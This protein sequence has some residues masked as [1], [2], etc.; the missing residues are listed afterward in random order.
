ME[1]VDTLDYTNFLRFHTGSSQS[2]DLTI[3]SDHE[4]GI[5]TNNPQAKLQI[6]GG[7]GEQLRIHAAS[8]PIIQFTEGFLGVQEKKGF[9]QLSG[10]DL[11]I[12]TNSGNENGK[13]VVRTNGAD[14]ISVD[15][16][17]FVSVKGPL[18]AKDIRSETGVVS[19][20]P[21]SGIPVVDV[22]AAK[23]Q[24]KDNIPLQRI[25]HQFQLP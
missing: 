20:N 19:L 14:R 22:H 24:I 12:G 25:P 8:D 17:G 4:V 9:V 3:T 18:Y 16:Y 15:P 7:S 2:N 6:S 1:Y 13:F 10:D 21:S 23:V 11:R 5:G